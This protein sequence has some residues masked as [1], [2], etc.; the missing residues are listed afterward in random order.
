MRSHKSFDV[1]SSATRHRLL[2]T[3]Y[4]S[5]QDLIML[6]AAAAGKPEFAWVKWKDAGVKRLW[7]TGRH[8]RKRNPGSRMKRVPVWTGSEGALG[9]FRYLAEEKPRLF[10][11]FLA[12]LIP[13]DIVVP[14]A[15]YNGEVRSLR[16]EYERRGVPIEFAIKM[17]RAEPK[18]ESRLLVERHGLSVDDIIAELSGDL[19][20]DR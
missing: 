16:Q 10:F 11:R 12:A 9:Y 15:R 8:R 4:R 20:S 17:L 6:A 5:L 13:H 7:A 18:S 1:G 3:K 2:N 14:S 19:R